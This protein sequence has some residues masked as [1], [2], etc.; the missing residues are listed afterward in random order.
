MGLSQL[1]LFPQPPSIQ[2]LLVIVPILLVVWLSWRALWHA[3]DRAVHHVLPQ[4]H[5]EYKREKREKILA[6]KAR[7]RAGR[8][9]NDYF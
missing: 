1:S 6:E 7:Y 3:V 5:R 2:V 4:E 9:Y 8:T